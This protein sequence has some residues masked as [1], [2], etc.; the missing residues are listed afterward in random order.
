[1]IA[2]HAD[3]AQLAGA[4]PGELERFPQASVDIL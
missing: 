3:S 1:M 2:I 4:M